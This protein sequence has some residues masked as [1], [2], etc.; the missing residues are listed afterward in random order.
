MNKKG[1]FDIRNY[2]LF[3]KRS[4]IKQIPYYLI[5]LLYI[6]YVSVKYI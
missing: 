1:D 3:I 6:L 4:I 5:L 2:D